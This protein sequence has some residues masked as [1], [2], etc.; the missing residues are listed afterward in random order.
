MS[1]PLMEIVDS[2]VQTLTATLAEGEVSAKVEWPDTPVEELADSDLKT[3]L[4]QVHDFAEDLHTDEGIPLESFQVLVTVQ[5]LFVKTISRA[6]QVRTLNTL[7]STLA[8]VL[9]HCTPAAGDEQ[10]ICFRVERHRARD[11]ATNATAGR[12]YA[13]LLTHWKR[14][15]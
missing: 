4:I 12:Y 11:L 10:A 6:A 8:R 2:L 1:D 3:L 15:G 5:K 9:R 13:E 14:V 7:T